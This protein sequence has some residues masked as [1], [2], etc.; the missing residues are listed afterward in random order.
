MTETHR[1]IPPPRKS[2]RPGWIPSGG[3]A[4]RVDVRRVRPAVRWHPMRSSRQFRSSDAIAQVVRVQRPR[5]QPPPLPYPRARVMK[6]S[7]SGCCGALVLRH[8]S[9]KPPMLAIPSFLALIVQ[10][11]A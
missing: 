6:P 9:L 10:P 8:S 2:L 4:H 1:R 5:S 11:S 7:G 3:Q